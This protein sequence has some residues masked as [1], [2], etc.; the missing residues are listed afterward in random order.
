MH[1]E[2]NNFIGVFKN[3][4]SPQF[5]ARAIEVF[6]NAEGKGLTQRRNMHEKARLS[7]KDTTSAWILADS[8]DAM[9]TGLAKEFTTAFWADV[10]QAYAD[11]Y[12]NLREIQNAGVYELKIQR[13]RKSEGYHVWHSESTCRYSA[14][15]F[16][17][18]ILYLNDVEDGGETEFL[19]QSMRVKP[20]TGTLLVFPTMFTHTHRGN[21]PLAGDKYILNGWV[22]F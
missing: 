10:M 3:A 22:E 21:P 4:F 5:C 17:A 19:Y 9:H 20:E 8:F 18:F 7:H 11:A 2:I 1:A 12:D 15:R 14:C 6:Q 13:V 16:L